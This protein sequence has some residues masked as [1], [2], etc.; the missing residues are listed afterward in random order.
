M[1]RRAR[2]HLP[3]KWIILKNPDGG[4]DERFAL[5]ENRRLVQTP[6]ALRPVMMAPPAFDPKVMPPIPMSAVIPP[7]LPVPPRLRHHFPPMAE[8]LP[9]SEFADV[10]RVPAPVPAVN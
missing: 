7:E 8:R 4:A 3:L 2:G 9:R 5:D 6:S 10:P 1:G